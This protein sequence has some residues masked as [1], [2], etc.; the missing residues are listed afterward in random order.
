MGKEACENGSEL[1]LPLGISAN[2]FSET[3]NF[4]L[5]KLSLGGQGGGLLD[6]GSLV[7]VSNVHISETAS[8]CRLDSWLLPFLDLYAIGGYVDG[9]ADIGLRPGMLP[10]LRTRGP[11]YDLKLNF[12]GPTAGLGGTLAGGFKPFKERTTTVFGLADLNFTRTFL[13]FDRVVASLDPVDVM[14][15]SM[16]LGVRERILKSA[17]LGD[18]HISVWGGG[19]YQGVQETMTGRL[20]ILPLDFRA[21]VQAVNP[22]NTLVGGRL[23][24]G[25]HMV[26]EVEVGLGDRK[27]VMLEATFRF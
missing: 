8:T 18:L 24:I 19:M 22:W 5:P 10:I 26:L 21:N 14:V 17:S 12:E 1:P 16:R 11:K 15:F 23:E 4:G 25:K 2:V 20:G 6:V 7:R 27:S 3:Q 9:Q 13:D